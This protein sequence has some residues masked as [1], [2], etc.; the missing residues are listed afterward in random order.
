MIS[1]LLSPKTTSSYLYQVCSICRSVSI[2]CNFGQWVA[3]ASRVIW[4]SHTWFTGSTWKHHGTLLLTWCKMRQGRTTCHSVDTWCGRSSQPALGNYP[5]ACWRLYMTSMTDICHPL[6]GCQTRPS[7]AECLR[8]PEILACFYK[9]SFSSDTGVV[10]ADDSTPW[11]LVSSQYFTWYW[12]LA[13]YCVR[14]S[15]AYAN[16]DSAYPCS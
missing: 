13:F 14:S 1:A 4:G 8:I 7:I 16:F 5:L 6:K 12:N 2:P 9:L 3:S 11:H 15:T 10:A